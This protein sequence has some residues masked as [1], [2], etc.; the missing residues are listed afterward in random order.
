MGL[1]W[2]DYRACADILPDLTRVISALVRHS[3]SAWQMHAG[4]EQSDAG[5][6]QWWDFTGF[7]K[8]LIFPALHVL[9]ELFAGAFFLTVLA[10]FEDLRAW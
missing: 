3:L 9:T 6:F 8:N 7:S 1:D 4:A 5:E 2:T 10:Y